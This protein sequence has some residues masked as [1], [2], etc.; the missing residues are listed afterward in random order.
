MFCFKT[1][2]YDRKI[3]YDINRQTVLACVGDGA[4]FKSDASFRRIGAAIYD[5][6]VTVS[7]FKNAIFIGDRNR[8]GSLIELA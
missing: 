7:A 2:E 1:V 6:S 3:R 8:F 5:D 4:I